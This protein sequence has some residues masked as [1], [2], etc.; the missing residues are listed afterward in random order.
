MDTGISVND[1][2]TVCSSYIP[3]TILFAGYRLYAFEQ[4]NK[5]T[6][7]T[8]SQKCYFADVSSVYSATSFWDDFMARNNSETKSKLGKRN[9]KIKEKKTRVNKKQ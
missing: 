1:F 3:M 5:Q 8:L 2:I 4:T 7:Q 9:I 6:N